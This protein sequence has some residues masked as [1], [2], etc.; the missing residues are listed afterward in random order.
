M[1]KY[2]LRRGIL[3]VLGCLVA[4]YSLMQLPHL[5]ADGNTHKPGVA[6]PSVD[7]LIGVPSF[8]PNVESPQNQTTRVPNDYPLQPLH[9]LSSEFQSFLNDQGGTWGVFVI[10]LVTGH[11]AGQDSLTLFPAAS[12]IK[13]PL[14]L[15]IYDQVAAGKVSLDEQITYTVDDWEDGAGLLQWQIE[16]GETKS[17]DDLVNLAITQSDNVAK[18]MLMR[19][20]G[21]ENL[22]AW[23]EAHGGQVERRD[24]GLIY[25][26]AQ[27]LAKMM[28]LLYT[29]QA[30]HNPALQHKLLDTLADTAF[31]DR[32]AAGVPSGVKVAHKIG[33]LEGVVNDVA[34]IWAPHGP[35]ILAALSDG[36]TDEQGNETI[37]GLTAKAYTFLEE[38]HA[39]H[40]ENS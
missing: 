36:V 29:D 15:Y 34:L 37:S 26:N 8:G 3:V 28:R 27:T 35:F 12:T 32:S 38:Q 21:Q 30:F 4:G 18:N 5:L 6:T 2:R 13:L 24:D 9:A 19:R 22:F 25:T 23:I 7:A 14:A 40:T 11:T 20:F 17:I 39:P 33:N 1:V 31:H 10:D 16:P